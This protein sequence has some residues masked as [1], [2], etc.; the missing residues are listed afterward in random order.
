MYPALIGLISDQLTNN[1]K[2][3]QGHETNIQRYVI[4]F[5]LIHDSKIYFSPAFQLSFK[6][7]LNLSISVKFGK[8]S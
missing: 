8:Y 1:I 6:I 3:C 5:L 2:V 7:H 4:S